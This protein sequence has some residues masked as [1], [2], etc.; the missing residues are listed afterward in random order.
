MIITPDTREELAHCPTLFAIA[1]GVAK[2]LQRPRA[3]FYVQ[4]WTSARNGLSYPQI[5]MTT[6][7]GR[8]QRGY[9]DFDEDRL[10]FSKFVHA[11]DCGGT[12]VPGGIAIYYDDPAMEEKILATVKPMIRVRNRTKRVVKRKN[13][14]TKARKARKK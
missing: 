4:T 7:K 12:W 11:A 6:M 2:L 10:I 1:V 14:F 8:Y 9:I 13:P 5:L 3:T